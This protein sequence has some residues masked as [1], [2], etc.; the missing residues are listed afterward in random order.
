MQFFGKN[1]KNNSNFGSWRTPL[2]K[3]LDPPL[4]WYLSG[5]KSYLFAREEVN[6]IIWVISLTPRKSLRP[7]AFFFQSIPVADPGFSRGGGVNPPGGAWTRQ[8]FPKTAWNRKNLDAQGGACVPHAPPRSAN[9]YSWFDSTEADPGFCRGEQ[10]TWNQCNH[11]W[12]LGVETWPCKAINS[13]N[14]LFS[15]WS[16]SRIFF[17]VNQGPPLERWFSLFR[18]SPFIICAFNIPMRLLM[19]SGLHQMAAQYPR[20]ESLI[21]ENSQKYLFWPPLQSNYCH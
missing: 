19:K 3:I 14:L 12:R 2:G 4:K 15:I 21:S 1:L 10:E 8:I 18:P 5:W 16:K 6:S 13:F 9:V 20:A 11:L 17:I 7:I